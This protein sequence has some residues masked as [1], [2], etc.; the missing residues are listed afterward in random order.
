MSI[1]NNKYIIEVD[2]D[3]KRLRRIF[4]D[5]TVH[6]ECRI[7]SCDREWNTS[8]KQYAGMVKKQGL[9]D[10]GL[11]EP[12]WIHH[13][14]NTVM[15]RLIRLEPHT[16]VERIPGNKKVYFKFKRRKPF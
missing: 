4:D 10:A 13:K 12:M 3:A 15:N 5:L 9:I 1:K 11:I 14:N 8:I 7:D 16:I 2:K 6:R